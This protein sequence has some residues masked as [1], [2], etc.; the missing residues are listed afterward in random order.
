MKGLTL[1]MQ[2]A[3]ITQYNKKKT[4]IYK[5]Q[6]SCSQKYKNVRLLEWN[7]LK[8]DRINIGKCVKKTDTFPILVEEMY[9]KI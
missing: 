6:T 2:K 7:K 9:G 5:G 1:K 4:K 3:L 8:F